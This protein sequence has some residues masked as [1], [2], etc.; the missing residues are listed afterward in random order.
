MQGHE[1]RRLYGSPPDWSGCPR[2]GGPVPEGSEAEA[3][4][5]DA[6]KG[7]QRPSGGAQREERRRPA[8]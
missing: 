3:D 6:Q 8:V 5:V 4:R 2:E 7:W 1:P